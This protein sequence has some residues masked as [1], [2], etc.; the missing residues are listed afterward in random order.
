MTDAYETANGL[1]PNNAADRQAVAANGYTN[2]ENYLNGLVSAVTDSKPTGA[3]AE[4]LRLFPNPA[5]GQF[6]VEHPRSGTGARLTLHNLLGQQVTTMQA[7]A[8]DTTTPMSLGS[9]A[10]G[11]Y[12]L[13]YTDTDVSLTARC[14]RE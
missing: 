13:V 7:V 4:P 8:D 1:N 11:S 6:T 12:L 10:Q 14:T 2:L 3:I 5:A 9:L